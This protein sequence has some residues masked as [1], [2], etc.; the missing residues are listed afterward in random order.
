[1]AFVEQALATA[2]Y[3]HHADGAIVQNQRDAAEAASFAEKLDTHALEGFG[4]AFANQDRLAIFYD[5]LDQVIAGGAAAFRQA[6]FFVDLE[7]EA[8][9]RLV[10]LVERDVET[11][12]IEQ[13]A[14]LA[15]NSFEERVGFQGG[16]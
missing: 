10:W 8:T 7:F 16:A 1:M 13:A 2:V 3:G 5:V 6:R 4:E 14:H 9:R 12:Y 15:V 11:A